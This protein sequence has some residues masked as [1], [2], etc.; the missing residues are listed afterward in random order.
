MASVVDETVSGM[1][2]AQLIDASTVIESTWH[3]RL[4]HGY[5]TPWLGRDQILNPVEERLREL[6]IRSRG[7][8]GAWK[9][10]VANQDHSVMQGVEAVDAILSGSE[11]QTYA[12][13]R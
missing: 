3:R 10:E 2:R 4:D 6:G 7:R 1:R 9:Y 11:E 8:F 12:D 13:G 5:P